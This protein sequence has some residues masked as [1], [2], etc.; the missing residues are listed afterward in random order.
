MSGLSPFKRVPVGQRRSLCQARR[1]RPRTFEG[2]VRAAE[3]AVEFA[4]R[5]A[6]TI[7]RHGTSV[8]RLSARHC[9]AFPEK[10]GKKERKR[11]EKGRPES[12]PG[13]FEN[14]R[15]RFSLH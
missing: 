12:R 2:Y 6:T 13:C 5:A 10:K 4:A 14:S 1:L 7:D 15:S 3:N 9:R 8:G 11:E